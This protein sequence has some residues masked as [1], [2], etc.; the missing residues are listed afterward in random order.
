MSQLIRNNATDVITNL[1]TIG[2]ENT[3]FN[4]GLS[5]NFAINVDKFNFIYDSTSRDYYIIQHRMGDEVI[6]R[7]II[8]ELTEEF[9]NMTIDEIKNILY[10]SVIK[11]IVGGQ[12]ILNN[13]LDLY[14]HLEKPIKINNKIIIKFPFDYLLKKLMLVGMNYHDVKYIIKFDSNMPVFFS[15]VS[16]NIELKY[17]DSNER[18]DIVMNQNEYL[19]QYITSEIIDLEV[20]NLEPQSQFRLMANF[21]GITKGYFIQGN[22]DQLMSIELCLNSHTRLLYDDDM[23]YTFCQRISENLI[24]VPLVPSNINFRELTNTT[25]NGGLNQ[26]RMDNITFKLEFSQPQIKFSIHSI[27]LNLAIVM[28]GMMGIA[29]H[30]EFIYINSS[31][32]R[33]QTSMPMP[34]PMSINSW[35]QVYQII[36][37]DKN[38][39][40]PITHEPFESN[41]SYCVCITCSHNFNYDSMCEWLQNH[42]NCPM[43]R[44]IWTNKIKYINQLESLE[45]TELT[46]LSESS[47]LTELSESLEY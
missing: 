30:H 31:F 47:K 44:T 3:R 9:I 32:N 45:L 14:A 41:D 25:Y 38:N 29:Y 17:L 13:P 19:I 15:N 6:P 21:N 33:R 7:T 39:I 27:T 4:V 11:V 28:S 35:Q 20:L 24:Y 34:M 2:I 46:E 18:H 23:I 43:C 22:I 10:G 1:M 5:N 42:N 16:M 12:P 8:F 37:L 26:S 40:C 36:N